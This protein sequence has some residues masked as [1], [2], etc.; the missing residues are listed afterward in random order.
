[1]KGIRRYKVHLI[2]F[3]SGEF[4]SA[5]QWLARS[6]L[7][8]GR[9][10]FVSASSPAN[11]QDTTFYTAHRDILDAPR[12]AGYWLWKP[13]LILEKL[14]N[15][16][17]GDFVI[18]CDCG[19]YRFLRAVDPLLEWADT[20]G[21]GAMPGVSVP[22]FGLNA[23]WTKRDC[24]VYMDCDS[25]RF[26]QHPQIQAS[27]SVWKKTRATTD[28]V[29]EWLRYCCDP[30]IVTDAPN[31]CGLNNLPGFVEHRHDQSVLT[32]L[33]IASGRPFMDGSLGLIGRLHRPPIWSSDSLKEPNNAIL[34]AQ[35]W[36][37]LRDPNNAILI[38]RGW[39]AGV[40][41]SMTRLRTL[42]RRRASIL[43][44]LPGVLLLY[45]IVRY[46]SRRKRCD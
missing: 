8:F 1:M 4:S 15:V 6:A 17:D 44:R 26:W 29:A 35:G 31:T 34:R 27:Y 41:Y 19:G 30:R 16:A 42:M 2:T 10:D 33:V 37:F 3:A 5:Q 7:E 46:G 40:I 45:E 21:D 24:F 43:K 13:F 12:G 11:I 28:F 9:I 39:S 25:E 20:L 18:Y 32:N 38:A 22:H 14:T 36:D 23:K